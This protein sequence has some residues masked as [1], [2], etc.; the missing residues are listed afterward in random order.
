MGVHTHSHTARKKW[1]HYFWEFLMLF[2][3]VFAGF[4]AEYQLEH[5]IEKDR[6]K[7]FAKTLY[8]ELKRDTASLSEI[9][10]RT[11]LA[12]QSMDSLVALL[13]QP[14]YEKNSGL[15]YYYCG[16]GMYNFFFTANEATLQ[17]MKSSGAIRYFNKPE[18]TTAISEYEHQIRLIYQLETNLYL[19]Y[20]E[21][22]KAQLKVFDTRY[23][24]S[25]KAWEKSYTGMM[26]FL[27][28][29]KKQSIPLLNNDRLQIAEFRNWAQNKGELGKLKV[30]QYN[31]FLEIANLL[32]SKLKSEYELQ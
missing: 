5:K 22:R 14:G 11:R 30:A 29:L 3:A 12:F 23:I 15:L 13:N 19:N 9:R 6:A 21:T 8:T 20:M 17:Q 31:Q 7:D 27:S 24:Y 16:L 32:L 26:E 2:L 28:G 25:A 18:L 1:T 4:M 10:N